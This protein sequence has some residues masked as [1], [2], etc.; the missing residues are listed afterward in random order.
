MPEPVPSPSAGDRAVPELDAPV[1]HG[2][3]DSA[4][5]RRRTDSCI[6]RPLLGGDPIDIGSA[7]QW[8]QAIATDRLLAQVRRPAFGMGR[9]VR[10][11][12]TSNGASRRRSAR[13]C[14]YRVAGGV[15][16][17]RRRDVRDGALDAPQATDT[18]AVDVGAGDGWMAQ[19]LIASGSSTV[20]T[21][22]R[23]PAPQAVIE[24]LLY[25]GSVCRWK[26]SIDLAYAVDAVHHAHDPLALLRT[27]RASRVAGSS[28][29]TIRTRLPSAR[30]PLRCSTRS[31]TVD[32]DRLAGPLS[33]GFA[34]LM[35]CAGPGS[36]FGG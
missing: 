14:G 18:D 2:L 26:S 35:H 9:R 5:D 7:A 1:Q 36:S 6:D 25:D 28:S 31:A 32:F 22:G 11:T 16:G 29:R 12:D 23:R 19:A 20:C 8:A 4:L 17:Y 10:V 13:G 34:W 15:T 21:G 3:R 30:G 27:W 33:A 24:P